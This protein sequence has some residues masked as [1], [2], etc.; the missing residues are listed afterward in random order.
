[1]NFT[2]S[3]TL[4]SR[5]STA[6]TGPVADTFYCLDAST[7]LALTTN[8]S[9]P[10]LLLPIPLH[11]LLESDTATPEDVQR[12]SDGQIDLAAAQLLHQLQV[13]QA[14]P[15]AGVRDGDGAPLR[16]LLHQ[17]MIDALL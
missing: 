17:R 1:M 4:F 3:R 8:T 5:A 2:T 15:T 10:R 16:Q 7:A 11:T 14:T 9:L 12:A 13:L 6:V